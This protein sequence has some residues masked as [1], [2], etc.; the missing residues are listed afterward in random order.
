MSTSLTKNFLPLCILAVLRNHASE[1]DIHNEQGES[2]LTQTQIQHFVEKDFDMKTQRK[3]IGKNLENLFNAGNMDQSLGFQLEFLGRERRKKSKAASSDGLDDESQILHVG[4]RVVE[5]AGFETSEIRMLIDSVI[6]SSVIPQ[7]Q[8]KQLVQRLA[9]LA[10]ETIV[11]PSVERE[12]H[13]R[14]VNNQFFLNVEI[15][16][17]AILRHKTTRF[18]LG[19]FGKDGKIHKKRIDGTIREYEATPIQLLISNGHYYVLVVFPKSEEIYKFRIDL[20]LDIEI[21]EDLDIDANSER[22]SVDILKYRSHHSYMMS[23]KVTK[24]VLRIQKTSLHT[25]Y[26]QFGPRLYFFN[27]DENTI[28][29]EFQSDPD[30]V[31]FWALQYCQSVEVLSPQK[32]RDDLRRTGRS[33]VKK[34][35]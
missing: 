20:L 15:L 30:S 29:V 3:A 7:S 1:G 12:G 32:L 8:I 17:E 13:T 26:E 23:G 25:L 24:I 4:W 10:P 11:V 6:A 18:F 22:P 33:I 14:A 35:S 31:F 21:T 5:D 2:F 27:E 19:T 34:Y 16:N 9:A 28:E